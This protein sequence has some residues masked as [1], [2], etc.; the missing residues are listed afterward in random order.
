[1]LNIKRLFKQGDKKN[2][3][4]TREDIREEY[5]QNCLKNNQGPLF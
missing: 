5:I 3:L 1:M 2:Q 4:D